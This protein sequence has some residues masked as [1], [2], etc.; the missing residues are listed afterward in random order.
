MY[1]DDVVEYAR[2]VGELRLP[3]KVLDCLPYEPV[4]GGAVKAVLNVEQWDGIL[5][6]A[7]E[8]TND[9]NYRT[10]L[11]QK[12]VS[13]ALCEDGKDPAAALSHQQLDMLNA[14]MDAA[15]S[16][17]D[18]DF[19]NIEEQYKL[20][21][22]TEHADR[23]LEQRAKTMTVEAVRRGRLESEKDDHDGPSV[24][25]RS[26]VTVF[27][28]F[29]DQLRRKRQ[30]GKED[31]LFADQDRLAAKV[32]ERLGADA[33]IEDALI[34]GRPAAEVLAEDVRQLPHRVLTLLAVH[35]KRPSGISPVERWVEVANT[36]TDG[37]K[38][39]TTS[40]SED[41]KE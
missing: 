32:L 25:N 37:A 24:K 14:L 30:R 13:E 9:R 33:A 35:V 23:K 18:A 11:I 34:D 8:Q 41:P 12:A 19:L 29:L 1:L 36:S 22:A 16:I 28:D 6:S 15:P 31:A 21:R 4:G 27:R 17:R 39:S 26:I 38:S 5:R 10:S 20:Y 40:K 3:I 2:P 7:A